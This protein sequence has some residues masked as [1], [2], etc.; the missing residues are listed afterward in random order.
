MAATS[1]SS[2]DV[3]VGIDLGTTYSCVGVW[4]D[5]R[6]EIIAN[7]LGHRTTPSVVAF[8]DKERLVGDAAMLQAARNPKNTV[9]D[10]K[11]LIGRHFSEE[12]VQADSKLWPFE[13][14][15]GA[16]DK[17]LIQVEFEGEKREFSAEEISAAVLQSMKQTASDFLG[18]EVKKAVVTVP[19]YFSDAQR[20]ATKDAGAIAGLEVLRIINEP[21]AAAMAYGLYAQDRGEHNI[22]VYDFGG[23][24]LDVSALVIA[25]NVFEVKATGGDTHLGG[26]DIDN[27]LVEHFARE[28]QRK[29]KADI[30]KSERALR[31]LRTACEKLKRTLSTTVEAD[32]EVDSLHDGKDFYSRIT[33]ARFN[34]LCSDI[35]KR[36]MEPLDIVLSKAG[37]KK[38]AID[39]I[40]LVGGSTKIP[41]IQSLLSN[42]FGGKKLNKSINPD[43]AVAYGAAIQAAILSGNAT[44]AAST[45]LLMDVTPLNLG[46]ETAGGRMA[47]VVDAGVTIPVSCKKTFST[48]SNNQERV[49]VKVYEGNR[50]NVRDNNLLGS[51]VISGIPPMPRGKPQLEVAF[52]INADGLLAVRAEEKVSGVKAEVTIDSSSRLSA[53]EVKEKIAEAEKFAE[54]DAQA[55]ATSQWINRIESYAIGM[56]NKPDDA[57]PH[58]AYGFAFKDEITQQESQALSAAGNAAIRWVETQEA[59]LEELKAKQAELENIYTPIIV[60]VD[61]R[62]AE[63]YEANRQASKPAD[64]QPG[65]D[66]SESTPEPTQG[67]PDLD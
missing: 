23:G 22:L 47:V 5:D 44:G 63:K 57:A 16:N 21:T 26:E 65:G 43:E 13:I 24:T 60:A 11:R 38:E 46:C 19:A 59:T 61:Q 37:F 39:E 50:P 7:S 20:T 36:C 1:S 15:R 48:N 41:H 56:L 66:G 35:W 14:V 52:D 9:F 25:D 55:R 30:T 40:V 10:A 28:F 34:E 67:A 49:T 27:L 64:P 33:R 2:T 4:R 51:F 53:D 32:L 3:A 31:R 58:P 29:E 45:A 12:V 42:Y 17:P 18:C 6:V 8:T 62:M 54:A